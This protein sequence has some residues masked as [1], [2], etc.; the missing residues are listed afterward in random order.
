MKRDCPQLEKAAAIQE[1][2]CEEEIVNLNSIL[3]SMENKKKFKRGLMYIDVVVAGRRLNAL[4]DTGASDLFMSK[5]TAEKLDL[6]VQKANG[7]VKTINSKDT[8]IVGVA[9]GVQLKISNWSG[10]ESIS[11]IPIDDF[12]FVIGI[13]FLDRIRAVPVPFASCLHILDP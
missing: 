9:K 10:K 4:V 13:D 12:N 7:F 3:S 8:P 1:N 11:V 2:E 6:H 5:Q